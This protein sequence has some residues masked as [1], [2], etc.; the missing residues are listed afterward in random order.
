MDYLKSIQDSRFKVVSQANSGLTAT[1]NR[2]LAE[3]DNPW[4]VRQDADDIAYPN[5]IELITEYINKYPEHIRVSEPHQVSNRQ[6]K[7]VNKNTNSQNYQRMA[8]IAPPR[9]RFILTIAFNKN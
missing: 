7:R 3:A 6:V 8:K 9:R 4:L 5:R 2:M 1:L